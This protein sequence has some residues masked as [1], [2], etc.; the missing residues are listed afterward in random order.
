MMK[1]EINGRKLDHKIR[2]Q[3]RIRA[4]KIV[5]AG[6]SPEEVIKALG[7]HRS[8]KKETSYDLEE[9]NSFLAVCIYRHTF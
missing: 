9:V 1:K 2:E 4:A 8:E 3:I 6:N 5:K 7:F